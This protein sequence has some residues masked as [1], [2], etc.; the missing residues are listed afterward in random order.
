MEYSISTHS[1]LASIPPH[2][3]EHTTQERQKHSLFQGSGRGNSVG[4]VKL[5]FSSMDW[6]PFKCPTLFG[7]IWS[8]FATCKKQ[9]FLSFL[10]SFP[11]PRSS[12]FL[13]TKSGSWTV[14]M[15]LSRMLGLVLWGFMGLYFA[16]RFGLWE[17]PFYFCQLIWCIF[18]LC[19]YI[20]ILWAGPRC[21]I[22]PVCLGKLACCI[23]W[24]VNQST[25][26]CEIIASLGLHRPWFPML[27]KKL[28]FLTYGAVWSTWGVNSF[29]LFMVV[30]VF[31]N[32][33][34]CKRKPCHVQTEFL[35]LSF[36]G[37]AVIQHSFKLVR[38]QKFPYLL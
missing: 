17:F 9:A 3:P 14:K 28:V 18:F 29:S 31:L 33:M 35:E 11:C 7:D 19:F 12:F 5:S 24:K 22:P 32:F 30:H 26:L 8:N 36:D 16:G 38:Y 15:K 6:N 37:T 1:L 13:S 4:Q 34:F 27:K 20:R 23:E 25:S 2:S 10:L 21:S